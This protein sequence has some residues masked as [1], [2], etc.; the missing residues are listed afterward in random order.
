MIQREYAE[1]IETWERWNDVS[2]EAQGNLAN[3]SR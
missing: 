1:R 2:R 3:R